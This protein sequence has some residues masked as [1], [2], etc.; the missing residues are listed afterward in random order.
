MKLLHVIRTIDPAWGGPV[1][2][3]RQLGVILTKANNQ[4][5][6]ASLDRRDAHHNSQPWTKFHPLG[7]SSTTYG[8]SPKLSQWVRSNA[9][10]FDAV[11]L[12][13]IW[14]YASYGAWRALRGTKTPYFLFVHGALDPWFKKTYPLKHV[15]K[16][17]YWKLFEASVFN[18]ARAVLFTSE[19]EKT[20]AENAFLP[21]SCNPVVT[22]YGISDPFA[23]S[24]LGPLEPPGRWLP[25]LS[26][27]RYF[28][29]L[30]RVHRKKGIDLLLQAFAS[31]SQRH[32]DCP[33]LVIAGTGTTAYVDELK[34]I[35]ASLN[36]EQ[37]VHWAGPVFGKRKWEL[38][39][40]AEA[41]V[42]P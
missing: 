14:T 8:F 12:H 15:K 13:G 20:L 7:I 9:S 38:L 32:D 24:T 35:A 17:L 41:L 5:E 6:V 18:N 10:R 22:G 34:A 21:Y 42:L 1:E 11:V 25:G 4:L 2:G 30:S 26:Q 40:K 33:D 29:F 16:L 23:A 3:L 19:E 37:R 31:V 27:R 36:L 28:L 39:T